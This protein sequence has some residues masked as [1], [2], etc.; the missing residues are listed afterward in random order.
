MRSEK[1]QMS[2]QT[3]P[4]DRTRL[5]RLA[6]KAAHDK[7]TINAI[8][9]AGPVA[10]VG[11]ILNGAPHVTPTL[12]WREGDRVFW[13]GSAASRMLRAVDGTQV[14]LTVTLT[15]GL[16]LARSGFEHSISYR[17]AMLFGRAEVVSDPAA[18][19]AHLQAMMDQMFPGRWPQ[20]RP[21][22][23]QELTATAILTMPI[24]EA[25]AKISAGMP[26]DA[27]ED[28]TWPVWA[29]IVPILTTLGA[30][31]PAPDCVPGMALPVVRFG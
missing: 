1:V 18:K 29:G 11:H 10:H 27:A 19:K 17:S 16:V 4:T 9:D 13:H 6:D 20:L 24:N 23:V 30:P 7:A 26:D 28:R 8:L 12:H 21:M 5:R 25:S 14:C 2:R 15:D 3:A 22:T 31:Q